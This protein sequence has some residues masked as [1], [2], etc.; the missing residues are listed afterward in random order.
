MHWN[1]C[2]IIIYSYKNFQLNMLKHDWNQSELMSIMFAQ[3]NV[4]CLHNQIMLPYQIS[5]WLGNKKDII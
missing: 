2:A 4:T 1:V 3:K 5:Y